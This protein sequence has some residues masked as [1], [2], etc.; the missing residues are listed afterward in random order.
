[1]GTQRMKMHFLFNIPSHILGFFNFVGIDT[2]YRIATNCQN[3]FRI[4]KKYFEACCI[5]HEGKKVIDVITVTAPLIDAAYNQK[6]L[7]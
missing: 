6:L 3:F 7:F 5:D 4:K 2:S 1:M